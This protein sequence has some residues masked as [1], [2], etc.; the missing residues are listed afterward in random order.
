MNVAVELFI[1]KSRRKFD[2]PNATYIAR[3]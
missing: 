2:Y 1:R 3:Y